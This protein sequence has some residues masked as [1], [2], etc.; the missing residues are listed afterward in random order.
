MENPSTQA[1]TVLLVDDEAPLL[2]VLTLVVE[3]AGFEVLTA[4]DAQEA[5]VSFTEN[6]RVIAAVVTDLHMPGMDGLALVQHL[7]GLDPLLPIIVTTGRLP[8][9]T[10][11]GFQKLHVQEILLKPFVGSRL[12]ESLRSASEKFLPTTDRLAHRSERRAAAA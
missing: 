4:R 1:R 11:A 3:S 12:V 5:L 2:E 10:R 9:E 8:A 7:R 6:R